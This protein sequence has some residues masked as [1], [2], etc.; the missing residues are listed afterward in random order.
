M[1]IQSVTGLASLFLALVAGCAAP[2]QAADTTE[3]GTDDLRGRP[4]L[5]VYMGASVTATSVDGIV[6]PSKKA[7][8]RI[9]TGGEISLTMPSETQVDIG[10]GFAGQGV[11]EYRVRK[12]TDF[13]DFCNVRTVSGFTDKRPVDGW[14][15]EITVIDRSQALGGAACAQGPSATLVHLSVDSYNRQTARE[16]HGFAAFEG[17]ALVAFP[18][19]PSPKA[20]VKVLT[21]SS[22][23]SEAKVEFYAPRLSAETSRAKLFLK[24]KL[25]ADYTNSVAVND[26]LV[27]ADLPRVVQ[28]FG[29]PSLFDGGYSIG[30]TSGNIGGVVFARVAQISVVGT[31]QI[32]NLACIAR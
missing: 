18:A 17:E 27:A 3:E 20:A 12:T 16:A 8:I 25:V 14:R 2:T 4:M 7:E 19:A 32:A 28:S 6:L 13:Y 10:G 29:D 15:T 5:S 24:G 23:A 9:L 30:L 26:G 22:A 21:C 1:K 31:E 11:A